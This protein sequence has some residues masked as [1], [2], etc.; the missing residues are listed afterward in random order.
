MLEHLSDEK[1]VQ[2]RLIVPY[3]GVEMMAFEQERS[4]G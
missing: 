3:L 4:L 1:R 2:Q